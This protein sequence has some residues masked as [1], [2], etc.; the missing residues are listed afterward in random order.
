MKKWIDSKA[1][2]NHVHCVAC[3]TDNNWRI[4]LGLIGFTDGPYFECPYGITVETAPAIQASSIAKLSP[5]TIIRLTNEEFE[6]RKIKKGRAAWEW[7]HSESR[8][9]RLTIGRIATEFRAMIPRTGCGCLKDW[10]A[11]LDSIPF[12]SDDQWLWSI[13]IHNAVNKKLGKPIW[14]P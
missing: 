4:S 10:D 3:R 5:N 12:N 2:K 13:E 1:C 9:G 8:V 11:I 7:L 14:R 6:S